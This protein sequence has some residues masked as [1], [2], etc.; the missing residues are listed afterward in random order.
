MTAMQTALLPMLA[1]A[2]TRTRTLA[3]DGQNAGDGWR[4]ALETASQDTH[5][6]AAIT[7]KVAYLLALGN[8]DATPAEALPFA[9][10]DHE[11]T[12]AGQ[13]SPLAR[14]TLAAQASGQIRSGARETVRSTEIESARVGETTNARSSATLRDPHAGAADSCARSAE[15]PSP[16]KAA[17]L[18]G[19]ALPPRP[20]L[21]AVAS[22]AIANYAAAMSAAPTSRGR[23]ADFSL[24]SRATH[25]PVRVHVQWRA[26]VADAWIGLHRQAF[27]Q[28]PDIRAGLE[29]WVT[30]RGGVLGHVVCNGETLTRVPSSVQFLGAL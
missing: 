28:L 1:T 19:P 13:D 25:L 16:S 29:D 4:R 5:P 26:R 15:S 2:A 24:V 23:E 22:N 27:D 3:Q 7:E 18:P 9:S 6:A 10:S 11:P 21:Q 20:A 30:S 17:A 8:L 14:A 12:E